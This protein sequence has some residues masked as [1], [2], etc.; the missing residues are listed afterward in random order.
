[1]ERDDAD[2][3]E[4][5]SDEEDCFDAIQQQNNDLIIM[6]EEQQEPPTKQPSSIELVSD[7]E[8]YDVTP[9]QDHIIQENEVVAASS[10][11]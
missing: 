5:D 3:L 2:D 1:M 8:I 9:I 10:Q 6:E 4:T 7:N 11:L